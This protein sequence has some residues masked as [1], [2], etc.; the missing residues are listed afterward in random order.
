MNRRTFHACLFA[1][2]ALGGPVGAAEPP[3]VRIACVGDSITFGHGTGDR[4]K[5][6]YPAQLGAMLGD[7]YEVRNFGVNG[8]TMLKKSNKPYWKLKAFEQARDFQPDLV[9]LM[10]GTNDSKPPN[11]RHA[12]DFVADA[13][14]MVEVF[15][16]LESRPTVLLCRP[17]PVFADRW[18]INDKTVKGEIIPKIDQ[19]ADATGATLIDLYKPLEDKGELVP[20]KVHPNAGGAKIL[21]ETL[22]ET[23]RGLEK[24]ARTDG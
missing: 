20:D 9:I 24:A 21:A 10:L 13:T 16:K 19:V 12:D 6:S 2:A 7:G 8:A 3:S 5:N 11:W 1:L 15:Q 22:A 18:G 17:I 23:V 14:E 4:T